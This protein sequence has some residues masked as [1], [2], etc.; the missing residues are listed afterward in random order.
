VRL[1]AALQL[2]A[3]SH[4]ILTALL[5]ERKT[6]QVESEPQMDRST[7]HPSTSATGY[8]FELI[9]RQS[10]AFVQSRE[11]RV[12][13]SSRTL[14]FMPRSIAPARTTNHY[15]RRSAALLTARAPTQ[16]YRLP[17]KPSCSVLPAQSNRTRAKLSWRYFS[18]ALVDAATPYKLTTGESIHHQS[19]TESV[20]DCTG[21]DMLETAGVEVEKALNALLGQQHRLALIAVKAWREIFF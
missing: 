16:H 6:S 8:R 10:L 2:A 12:Q 18:F 3:S 21:A 14:L 20:G 19:T 5:C 1:C 17:V 15:S 13:D 4:T 9:G 11:A 7:S